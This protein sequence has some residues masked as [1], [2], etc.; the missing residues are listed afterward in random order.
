MSY[1]LPKSSTPNSLSCSTLEHHRLLRSVLR[2]VVNE[3]AIKPSLSL[4]TVT[5]GN[6]T[7]ALA[8]I[9]TW[10]TATEG[11][12]VQVIVVD[13]GIHHRFPADSLL[14]DKAS[15]KLVHYSNENIGFAAGANLAINLAESEYVVLLNPDISLS[16]DHVIQLFSHINTSFPVV[17]AI[18]MVTQNKKHLGISV[19]ASGFFS[20]MYWPYKKVPVGPSGGAAV[21]LKS[22]FEQLGGFDETYFAWGED[23]EL[24][25][26]LQ[27]FGLSCH[28]LE[29]DLP[30]VGGHS[31]VSKLEQK[32]KTHWL[33][34]NRVRV[35]R[36][37]FSQPLKLILLFPFGVFLAVN[38][39]LRKTPQGLGFAYFS[40]IWQGLC[41][42][43]EN[44]RNGKRPLSISAFAQLCKKAKVAKT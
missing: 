44:I 38:G 25:L 33:A 31:I 34:R 3:M 9:Q 26:R 37:Y 27:L 1:V 40:G 6:P 22:A 18:S 23:V 5:Y 42:R 30:H 17:T 36:T 41:M 13:N 2:T 11:F 12:D 15:R 19:N 8:N 39:I 21:F 28:V 14:A 4:V 29:L 7:V 35:F 16:K 24:A 10:M 20:D 32:T 43:H